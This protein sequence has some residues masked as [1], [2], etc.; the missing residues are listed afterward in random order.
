[1]PRREQPGSRQFLFK[2]PGE[3]GNGAAH[4][5]LLGRGSSRIPT[6]QQSCHLGRRFTWAADAPDGELLRQ[7][8]D[9]V[10]HAGQNVHVLMPVQVRRRNTGPEYFLNLPP[11]LGFHIGQIDLTGQYALGQATRTQVQRPWRSTRL[12]MSTPARPES[13]R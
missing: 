9:N 13:F 5:V 2:A 7:A 6:P 1:M 4:Q 10:R 8:N 3:D 12:G 11:K